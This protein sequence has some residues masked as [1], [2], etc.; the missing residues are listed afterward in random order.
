M[1]L[2]YF[3]SKGW[4]KE[5]LDE[6]LTKDTKILVA[7]FLGSGKAELYLAKQRPELTVLGSDIF[8]PLVN[9][10][11]RL[12]DGSLATSL[13][14]WVGSSLDKEEYHERLAE[15]ED[16]ATFFMVMRHNFHGKFGSYSKAVDLTKRTTETLARMQMPNFIVERRDALDAIRNAPP[17]SIIFADPPYLFRRRGK[18]YAQ[19]RG[20]IEFQKALAEA[21]KE[22]GLPFVLCTNDEPEVLKL[23]KGCT[24]QAYPRTCR[25]S[26]IHTKHYDEIVVTHGL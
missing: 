11:Q 14:K 16:A 21:L 15:I 17:G 9:F 5:K 6:L 22:R 25:T 26:K 1:A 2:R 3:G 24:I 13:Q 18:Y 4:F 19:S 23:Y 8:Q 7:P 12:Q 20:D 10:H